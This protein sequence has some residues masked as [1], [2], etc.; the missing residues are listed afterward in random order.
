MGKEALHELIDRVDEPEIDVVYFVLS[1]IVKE[2]K[3]EDYKFVEVEALLDE[4]D[5]IP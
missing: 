2:R 1:R 5:I 4:L 3:F